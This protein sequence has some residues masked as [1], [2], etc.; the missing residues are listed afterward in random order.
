MLLAGRLVIILGAG[1]WVGLYKP[2]ECGT[3]LLDRDIKQASELLQ[4][5]DFPQYCCHGFDD[6][7]VTASHSKTT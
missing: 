4:D 7:S 5:P 6:D 3:E 2:W 1:T